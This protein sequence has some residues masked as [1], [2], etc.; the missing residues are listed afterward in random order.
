[1]A[2]PRESEAPIGQTRPHWH[3]RVFDSDPWVDRFHLMCMATLGCQPT[4]PGITVEVIAMDQ[5]AVRA[6]DAIQ[7][8]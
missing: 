1:M 5:P 8:T 2:E 4:L 7:G 3:C 6:A